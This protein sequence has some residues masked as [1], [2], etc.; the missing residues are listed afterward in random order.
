MSSKRTEPHGSSNAAIFAHRFSSLGASRCPECAKLFGVPLLRC[1]QRINAVAIEH[2]LR[3]SMHGWN[4]LRD[5]TS[6]G[7][8]N[9]G[10]IVI[11]QCVGQARRVSLLPT[12]NRP[13]ECAITRVEFFDAVLL[14]DHLWT[15][16]SQTSF[17]CHND[18]AC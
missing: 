9:L 14:L 11:D 6:D 1:V 15:V 2:S 3:A 16:H 13:N 10:R 12:M 18:V 17:A 7:V 4:A 5:E 8:R